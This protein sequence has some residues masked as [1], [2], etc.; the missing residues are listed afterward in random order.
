MHEFDDDYDTWKEDLKNSHR[1]EYFDD[2]N[3]DDYDEVICMRC[4]GS[5]EGMHEST[6]CWA[7]G[8]SGV[9][10]ERKE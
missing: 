5:G 2:F 9:Q 4:S 10:Y 8:G 3:P 6:N 1:E 7:C